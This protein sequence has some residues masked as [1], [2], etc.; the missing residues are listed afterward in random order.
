M[1][2]PQKKFDPKPPSFEPQVFDME[3]PFPLSVNALH[4]PAGDN[5][6][7][8]SP[9]AKEYYGDMTRILSEC[10][11][12]TMTG[13][14]KVDLW[15]YEPDRR[16]R[17]IN[18]LTKSLFDALQYCKVIQDDAQIDETHI[19]R[20]ECWKGGKVRVRMVETKETDDRASVA[21]NLNL[22]SQKE[23]EATRAYILKDM[24]HP[25]TNTHAALGRWK[26]GI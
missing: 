25:S 26:R 21:E 6:I 1:F 3:L 16:R 13:R 24:C 4:I 7:K 8:L 5:K 22:E 18:N 23:K 17:D 20:C 12:G 9:R 10:D 14:I 19:Y 15:V 11:Y 2:D